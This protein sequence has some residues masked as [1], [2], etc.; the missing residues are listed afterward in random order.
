MGLLTTQAGN[1]ISLT[2][3]NLPGNKMSLLAEITSLQT[4]DEALGNRLKGFPC[5]R[6]RED[7]AI[8]M[9][10]WTLISDFS[11]RISYGV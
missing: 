6:I 7:M 10:T 2:N 11:R 9:C 5:A 1:A 3:A 8:L 4:N